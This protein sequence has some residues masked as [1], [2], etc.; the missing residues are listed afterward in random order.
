MEGVLWAVNAS[1]KAGGGVRHV[2]QAHAAEGVGP[3]VC[4]ELRAG[5]D[6]VEKGLG[7]TCGEKF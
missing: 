2:A 1:V 6:C 4:V 3:M 5:Q 7:P